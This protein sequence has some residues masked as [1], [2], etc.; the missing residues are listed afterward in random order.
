MLE[1]ATASGSSIETLVARARRPDPRSLPADRRQHVRGAALPPPDGGGGPAASA[2]GQGPVRRGAGPRACARSRARHRR[3]PSGRSPAPRTRC[4]CWSTSPQ[5]ERGLYVLCDYGAYL[6]PFGQAEPQ[7]V[8]R[9]RE[10]A[11]AIKARPVTVLFVGPTFPEIPALEKEVKPSTCRCPTSARWRPSSTCSSRGWPTTPTCGWTVDARTREQLVQ[12]LLG[13]TETEI[14]NAL[15][16]AAITLRG[17]GADA[18]PADPGREAQRHPPERRA[19]LQPPRARRPP[20]R[21]RAP[22]RSS[23]RRRP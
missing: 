12:A 14:E 5:A 20:R 21:L 11:W 23:C 8:R 15:A 4:R 7:L 19:D 10:L 22:A 3:R 9:L 17:I 6:A 2:T 13:L 1:A 18:H 16:K